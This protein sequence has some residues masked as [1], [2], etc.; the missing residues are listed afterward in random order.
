MNNTVIIGLIALAAILAGAFA[1][2][3]LRDRLPKHHL[4]D[5]TK[6]LVNVST[7]VVATVS[8][9]VLGLLISNA[10]TSFTR[11]GGQVTSLS[12]EMILRQYGADAE[13]ARNTLLKYAEHK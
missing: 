7:A 9:L 11:L 2:V 8:A 13:P 6:N 12:A 1:G 4:T 5:E 3:R 10:N